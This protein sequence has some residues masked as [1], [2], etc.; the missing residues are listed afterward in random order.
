MQDRQSLPL[1]QR[2]QLFVPLGNK[3][4][5]SGIF[6]DTRPHPYRSLDKS[7]PNEPSIPLRRNHDCSTWHQIRTPVKVQNTPSIDTYPDRPTPSNGNLTPPDT[8]TLPL[9]YRPPRDHISPLKN[10]NSSLSLS[11]HLILSSNPPKTLNH[12][13]ISLPLSNPK[14]PSQ[15][16]ELTPEDE[17]LIQRFV[18]LQ[19]HDPT[20]DLVALPPTAATSTDWDSSLLVKI[21]T[22]R[23][24]MDSQFASA[25]IVAWNVDPTTVFTSVMRN[26]YLVEFTSKEDYYRA[27]LGG[28][29]T[30]RGDLVAFRK[31]ASHADLHPNHICFV[32][33]WVQFLNTP[34][35]CLT[36][37]GWDLLGQKLGTTVSSPIEGY[38]NGRHFTKLKILIDLN[39]PLKDRVS[40]DHP[41]LGTVTTYCHYEK[42]SRICLFC[43]CL[44]HELTGCLDH[45]RVSDLLQHPANVGKYNNS[46]ILKPKFGK[47][48]TNSGF[49]LRPGATQGP[50]PQQGQVFR[51][52]PSTVGQVGR[53]QLV[54]HR[55]TSPVFNGP[56]SS[57]SNSPQPKRPRPAGLNAPAGDL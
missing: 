19:T 5:Y 47:W 48:M 46:E 50:S 22:D 52:P 18:G 30:Y 6:R 42:V 12:N 40:F 15:M 8:T 14:H 36:D 1:G 51:Q 49:V 53:D 24:V 9:I 11:Q 35:H 44:G 28:P 17:A 13:S 43:G 38:A 54:R 20:M 27:S 37:E 7:T 31:A 29:W 26:T 45:R 34:V 55:D 4:K 57:S 3:D 23:T 2:A 39:K 10:P 16:A 25:M 21:V 32:K 56:T 41:T 33:V